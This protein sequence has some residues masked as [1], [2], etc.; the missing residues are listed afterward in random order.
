MREWLRSLF[1]GSQSS[2]DK[3]QQI[4][5]RRTELA[6]ARD[7]TLRETARRSTEL[8]ETLAVT[9]V[10]A[11]R[12]LGLVM[13]D[14]QVQGAVALAEG[15]I[16]EMQTGEGKTLAAVPA[17]AWYARQRQG[18]HVMTAN[19]YLA[20]RD[21]QWMGPVYR[22]LGLSVGCIQQGSNSEERQRAY[23]CDVTYGTA[24]EMGF[25][26]LRDQLALHRSEQVHRPFN[27]AL[28]DEADSILID[29]A[30]Q[31]LVIAGDENE[32]ESL[33]YRVDALIRR[34]RQ[35]AHYSIDENERN[36]V[37]TDAGI[38]AVEEAFRCG[39]LF[40]DKNLPLHAAVQ[41][42]LHAHA[43]L[44]RDVDYIVK[45]GAVE[46]VD[47][48]KGRIIQERRWPAGLHTAIEAKE[49]VQLKKQGRILGS[50][51]LQNLIALYPV[52]CGMTGTAATQADEFR[53]VY[54][55]EVEVIPTNR[56][57]IRTDHPDV[58]FETQREKEAAVIAEIRRAHDSGQPILVGTAS[59]DESER[60]STQLRKVPHS[61]LNARNDEQEAAIVARAGERGAVMISTN[62]AGRGTDIKLGEGVAELGGLYVI[63]TNRHESRRIDNQLRGRSGRQGDPGCSR[64][65]ISLEDPLLVK[66]GIENPAYQ[67]DPESVQRI[68]E[69]QQGDLRRFLVNY[70][71]A[72]EGRRLAI[73][74]RRQD[75]LEGVTPCESEAERI[76]SLLTIDDLWAEY[77]SALSEIHG[78]IQWVSLT[79]GARDPVQ[80]Y[81]K[82]GGFDPF[83]EYVKK[84]DLLFEELLAA[85]DTET[86]K[87][88]EEA[89]TATDVADSRRGTTWTYVTTDQPF[90]LAMQQAIRE[91]VKRRTNSEL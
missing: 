23:N 75:T 62:M 47:E 35:V 41:D 4:N 14:V 10:V 60:L 7:E 11:A 36:V 5:N 38:R 29:E 52:V 57:M 80:N 86:P 77:L 19:D 51:T 6:N 30:R 46:S 3:V 69:G 21:A 33:A 53:S 20:R 43:L 16:A 56:P 27:V 37:L 66:Y 12:V 17:V 76:I 90:G 61:V 40:E 83:R 28:V 91:F 78:G 74:K 8:I 32:A 44:H 87:R 81:F 2:E 26:Y 68:I 49:G 48:F 39:N 67:H 70:E 9:A 84:V 89:G 24:N 1:S 85:I 73:Q 22:M 59:V 79:G 15:K 45:N 58:L 31:P 64:F 65:F 72:T 55:L 63:G 54:G 71:E 88:L 34:F 18:V 50:I 13:F 25:D 42:S 82:F